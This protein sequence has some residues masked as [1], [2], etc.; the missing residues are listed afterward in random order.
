MTAD[1]AEAR[2]RA[3]ALWSG[4]NYAELARMIEPVAQAL[5]DACAVSAGQE[6]LDVAAGNGNFAV[7]AARE[8][9]SVV[10]SDLTP[11]MVELGRARTDQEGLDVEWLEADAAELPFEDA[12]F[13]CVASVFGAMFAPGPEAVASELF[14]VARA[15]GTVGMANWPPDGF[16][17]QQFAIGRGY[18]PPSDAPSPTEWGREE[19]VEQRLAGLAGSL[20]VT[21]RTLPLRFDSTDAMLDFFADNAPPSAATRASLP[22]EQFQ[23]MQR[24]VAELAERHNVASDGSVQINSEYVLVVARKRG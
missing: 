2:Q 3:V 11:A 21:R 24:E 9:A 1:P 4:G 23:Q 22:R 6:V 19:V 16:S 15:G 10:A 14:R 17:G 18:A 20:E 13:D 7:V 8:G 12:R 5:A